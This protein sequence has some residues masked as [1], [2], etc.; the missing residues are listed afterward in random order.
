MPTL[1]DLRAS[2]L[3]LRSKLQVFQ[4]GAPAQL[5]LSEQTDPLGS[6]SKMDELMVRAFIDTERLR[7][8]PRASPPSRGRCTSP[9]RAAAPP[10]RRWL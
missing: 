3:R 6:L 9:T 10:A 7:E 4:Q 2:F 8:L 5:R 1:A